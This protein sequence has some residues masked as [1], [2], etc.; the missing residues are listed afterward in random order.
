MEMGFKSKVWEITGAVARKGEGQ[1]DLEDVLGRY[2]VK[3][4]AEVTL[5]LMGDFWHI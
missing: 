5:G 1:E 4:F 2:G 3:G